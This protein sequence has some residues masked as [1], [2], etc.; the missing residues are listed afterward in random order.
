MKRRIQI[1]ALMLCNCVVS[2]SQ[3]TKTID[4][5][6]GTVISNSGGTDIPYSAS[7]L[8][9]RSNNKGILLPRM[10]TTNRDA[11]ASPVAGLLLY[12][13]TTNQFNFYDGVAWQ[14]ASLN[15]QWGVNG[16]NYYYNGGNVGIGDSTPD[17]KLDVS[18]TTYTSDLIV[19]NNTTT[20]SINSTYGDI[21]YRLRLNNPTQSALLTL[22]GDDFNFGSWGQ[23]IILE[24]AT[25]TNY[26]GILHDADGMKF[27]NFGAT[28]NFYF[29]NSANNTV[30][31]IDPSGNAALDGTLT[32]NAGKGVAYN[33]N[34]STNLRIY[35]FTTG[36][37]NAVLP[38][39]G[40][41]AEGAIA[42]N[43]GFTG[44]P[45]VFVGDIDVTGGSSG[46]LYRVQ[47]QLY[48]CTT[49]SGTTTCKARLLNT[50]PNPV[51]YSIT[52]NCVA[53]GN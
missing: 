2:Y 18:G 37:F 12:N 47:L 41:S 49:A 20:Y 5:P 40:L 28:D 13:N 39:F 34:S 46:E 33:G 29:R 15:N 32:V 38:G 11:I 22:K 42:F 50:S 36:T 52:W 24:N 21:S 16:A 31:L 44:V 9:V 10:S 3:N 48:G 17:Y 53:I 43:G 1:L 8:D 4:S 26:G 25:N 51:N 45:K 23:H 30:A 35:T 14:A 27:R 19:G 7:I 6:N